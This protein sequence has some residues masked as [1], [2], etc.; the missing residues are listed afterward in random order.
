M[1]TPILWGFLPASV[2]RKFL[3]KT[4]LNKETTVERE[5]TSATREKETKLTWPRV[6]T[7]IGVRI[8]LQLSEATGAR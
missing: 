6:K 2:S 4:A 8:T 1:A 7:S 3:F 5:T